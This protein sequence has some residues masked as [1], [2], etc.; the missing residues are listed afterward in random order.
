[1]CLSVAIERP[2]DVLASGHHSGHEWMVVHNGR[3]YRCGY[4]KVGPG[5]PWFGKGWDDDVVD[6]IGVHGGV[7]FAEIDVHCGKGG[8]DDGY[9]IGFDCNHAGDAADPS[10]PG[11]CPRMIEFEQGF[12]IPYAVRSQEY[13]EGQCRSL[14][15]QAHD[16]SVPGGA[17]L[18]R[19]GWAR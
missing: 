2:D 7:S 6:A 15:E 3:G 11:A 8:P 14:C 5:H 10:L 1:M 4:V 18:A 19:R 17:G 16:A 12:G 13:V 9:W